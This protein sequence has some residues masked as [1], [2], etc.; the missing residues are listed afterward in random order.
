MDGGQWTAPLLSGKKSVRSRRPAYP[1]DSR[2]ISR[3]DAETQ[4]IKK[5]ETH[6]KQTKEINTLQSLTL[7]LIGYPDQEKTKKSFATFATL[8]FKT[9]EEDEGI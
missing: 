6:G 2:D 1:Q 5:H 3:R 9:N 8:R 7:F 4:R